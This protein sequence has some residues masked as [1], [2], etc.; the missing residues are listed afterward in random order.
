MFKCLPILTEKCLIIEKDSLYHTMSAEENNV[1]SILFIYLFLECEAAGT[2][3]VG[4]FFFFNERW[5][6]FY[7]LIFVYLRF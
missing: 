7:I 2:G 1:D 4:S 5:L 6:G 3:K